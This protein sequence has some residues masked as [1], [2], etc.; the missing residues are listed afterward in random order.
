MQRSR[1]S[2]LAQRIVSVKILKLGEIGMLAE[3]QLD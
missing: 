2:A 3:H 1:V